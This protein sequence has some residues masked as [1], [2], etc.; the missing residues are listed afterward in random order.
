MKKSRLKKTEPLISVV[1]PI[2][3]ANQFVAEAIDSVIAQNIGFENNIELILVDDGSTDN[4]EAICRE[5]IKRYPQNIQ[6]LKQAN[7]G[8][9]SAR[10][11][12][13]KLA[14]GQYINFFDADDIW[15]KDAFKQSIAF[16]ERH[17]RSVDFVASKIKFFE[18]SIDSHPSNYKF[19]RTRVID[20]EKEPDNPIFHIITCVFK[21]EALEG[22]R[23]DEQLPITE[24]GKL[25]GEILLDKKA[26]GVL[27]SSSYYYRKRS[28]QGSAIGNQF[29]N[30]AFYTT[31]PKLAYMSMLDSWRVD[32]GKADKFMQYQILSDLYW[33]LQQSSQ[34][35][36]N[37]AEERAYKQL[38]YRIINELEDE[39]IL[40]RR[41]LEPE[42]KIYLLRVKYKKEYAS[43]ISVRDGKY[44][45]DD[46]YL[47]NTRDLSVCI[48]FTQE[49]ANGQYVIEGLVS[50][51][52]IDTTGG[53]EACTS[54]KN[55]PVVRAERQQQ[56]RRFLGEL[57]SD[58]GAFTASM[59]I[60]N[61]DSL[62]FQTV[63]SDGSRIDLKLDMG[64]FSGLSRLNYSY[65]RKST[66]LLRRQANRLVFHKLSRLK[67]V[68]FELVYLLRILTYWNLRGALL[69]FGKMRQRNLY[70]LS[71]KA[72]IFEKAKPLL[73]IAETA[74]LIPRALF[75][76]IL[77]FSVK[78]FIKRPIW[79]VSDRVIAAGDNG[80]ALF[81]YIMK[82]ESTPASVYF[83]LS[84][85]SADYKHIAKYG[86]TLDQNSLKYKLMFLLSD[87]VISSH[88]D[89]ETTNPFI[90]QI[91]HYVDLFDFKF[92]FLQHGIIKDDLSE[93]LNRFSRNIAL[94]VT[95]NQREY[96]SLLQ[97]PYYYT[98]DNLLLSGLPR[99]DLL[100]NNSKG[101]LIIAPTYRANLLRTAANKNG[102]R[103]YDSAFKQS[104]YFQF[105]NNLINDKKIISALSENNMTGEFYLHPNFAAQVPDFQRNGIFNIPSFPYDYL[106]MFR[107]GSI[108]VSDYSSTIFDFAYLNKPVIYIHFD[109]DTFFGGH[110]YSQGDF[111]IPDKNG[112]GPVCKDYESTVQ[113]IVESI[114]KDPVMEGK[115]KKRANEFFA[116]HDRNNSR[117]VY[118][119]ILGVSTI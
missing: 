58:G 7:K 26:Y 49:K 92:V 85:K 19:K 38:I 36:L 75:L 88:A 42:Y 55:H 66:H 3:N 95:S 79:L 103:P 106:Q 27:K 81:R 40:T 31:V 98:K 22:R 4:T 91:D 104:D 108:L 89:T 62:T 109:I 70:F 18:D 68:Y 107:E 14:R 54:T 17:G 51:A 99:Y 83:V 21:R 69:Q 96:D 76:R 71:G 33:R 90:R 63:L 110:A 15:S 32:N 48:D 67:T 24:D 105:Y 43:H 44:F 101:K 94:F 113:A 29:K 80:E 77:Y 111:F 25:L 97:Y 1:M 64:Q 2:Y 59:N 23:F 46:M 86:K 78:P 73:L 16:L 37:E 39:V 93:W 20:L 72:K 53:I 12:G 41:N 118:E 74:V 57:I 115:Y 47:F 28:D 100:E 8:V 11:S 52:V 13:L 114:K 45:F 112:F 116:H 102:V 117:R 60:N 84:K 34:S 6:Y 30:K 87:F 35:I 82:Q 56:E 119:A 10:N 50:P 65:A 61:N 5:Y 9:S